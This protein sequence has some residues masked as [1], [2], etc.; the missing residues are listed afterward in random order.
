[1]EKNSLFVGGNNIALKIPKFKYEDTITFYR[2]VLK[3][4]YLGYISNSHA[5]QFGQTTLWLDCMENY[6]QHD[7]WL[8]VQTGDMNVATAYF[9]EI[10]VPRRDEVERHE[11]SNGYW[12]SDPTGT[13]LRINPKKE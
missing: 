3:L 1:M 4:P 2:E 12:I 7:V 10:Q 9:Q 6:S 5:F 8:D 13:I 11:N